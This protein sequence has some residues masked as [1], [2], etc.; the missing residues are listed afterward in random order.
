MIGEWF[1]DI[2]KLFGQVSLLVSGLGLLARGERHK[3]ADS[4][5]EP[6]DRE[7][8][9]NINDIDIIWLWLGERDL[10][11]LYHFNK[12]NFSGNNSS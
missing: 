6:A 9:A 8:K 11:L 7:N 2:W 3:T 10:L 12:S 4:R 1:K 5:P